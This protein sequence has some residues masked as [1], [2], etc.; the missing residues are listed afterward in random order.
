MKPQPGAA[1]G[2]EEG[3]GDDRRGRKERN[4]EEL[5][6]IGTLSLEQTLVANREILG[7]GLYGTYQRVWRRMISGIGLRHETRSCC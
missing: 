5:S 6:S 4:G 7:D 1:K 3:N 2:S